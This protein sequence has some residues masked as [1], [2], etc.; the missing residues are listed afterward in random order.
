MYVLLPD[1]LGRARRS[2]LMR[3]AEQTNRVRQL[4]RA[5][6]LQR[7]ARTASARA[8]HALALASS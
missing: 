2:A 1:E 6:R 5:R 7:R 3:D 4:A 8:R